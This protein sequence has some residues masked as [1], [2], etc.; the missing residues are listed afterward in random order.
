M[1]RERKSKVTTE[2]VTSAD[3]GAL[4]VGAG[5]AIPG[6]VCESM[7]DGFSDGLVSLVKGGGGLVA[8][9][10]SAGVM[11][12]GVSASRLRVGLV[13]LSGSE[14]VVLVVRAATMWHIRESHRAARALADGKTS[15]ASDGWG[16]LGYSDL[17]AFLHGTGYTASA[18]HTDCRLYESGP[19]WAAWLAGRV[20]RE[21]ATLCMGVVN[22]ECERTHVKDDEPLRRVEIAERAVSLLEDKSL[23]V[24]RALRSQWKTYG[25]GENPPAQVKPE[26]MSLEQERA[27]RSAELEECRAEIVKLG[28]SMALAREREGKLV[29]GLGNLDN[30]I[31]SA[32]A[33]VSITKAAFNVCAAN[34]LNPMEI[35]GT[36]VNG[37]VC[38]SDAMGAVSVSA[39]VERALDSEGLAAAELAAA[40]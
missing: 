39:D 27:A 10:K 20:H 3:G 2:S 35:V 38:V 13:G 34:G 29:I 7:S 25:M 21:M 11:L 16:K 40:E 9:A 24:A 37:L 36:G 15:S 14:A 5:T 23:T 28:N 6:V 18:F 17:K 4:A 12:A 26:D 19:V 22:N 32:A 1:A 8:V 31:A 30:A 33:G